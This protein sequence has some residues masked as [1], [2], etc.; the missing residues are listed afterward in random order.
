VADC[1]LIVFYDG[2]R[3][4]KQRRLI[5]K[6][7][8]PRTL[9]LSYLSLMP[10]ASFHGHKKSNEQADHGANSERQADSADQKDFFRHVVS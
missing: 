1:V 4:S 2:L 5:A 7:P 8:F 10:L 3:D 9:L 6:V